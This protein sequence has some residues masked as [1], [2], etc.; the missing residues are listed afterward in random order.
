MNV[1]IAGFDWITT[2]ESSPRVFYRTGKQEV[3]LNCCYLADGSGYYYC[4]RDLD[5]GKLASCE[6]CQLAMVFLN[7]KKRIPVACKSNWK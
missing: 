4:C 3:D 2:G 6:N 1:M 5:G 7:R